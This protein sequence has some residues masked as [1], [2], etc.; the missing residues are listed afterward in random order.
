MKPKKKKKQTIL[1][2]TPDFTSRVLGLAPKDINI[3]D[4]IKEI[5]QIRTGLE[6]R[7]GLRIRY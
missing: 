4:A 7:R 3:K 5:K 6:I 2:Y 1:G